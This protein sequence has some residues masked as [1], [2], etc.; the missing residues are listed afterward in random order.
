MN[1]QEKRHP[2]RK[3]LHF[4]RTLFVCVLHT[5]IHVLH[6]MRLQPVTKNHIC[7]DSTCE[8]CSDVANL[9]TESRPVTASGE[10]RSDTGF[11]GVTAQGGGGG[12]SGAENHDR[13]RTVLT[14]APLDVMKAMR[15]HPLTDQLFLTHQLYLNTAVTKKRSHVVSSFWRKTLHSDAEA[16]GACNAGGCV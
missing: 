8:K 16:G 12:P 2:A 10:G 13:T 4:L 6:K 11:D 15:L 5:K 3:Y 14:A 9:E 1:G 7:Y